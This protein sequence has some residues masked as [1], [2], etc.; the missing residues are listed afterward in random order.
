TTTHTRVREGYAFHYQ[1]VAESKPH[2]VRLARLSQSGGRWKVRRV[3][4]GQVQST[5]LTL[6]LGAALLAAAAVLFPRGR[7]D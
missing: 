1:T 3:S 7:D 4:D 6:W 5:W 2:G